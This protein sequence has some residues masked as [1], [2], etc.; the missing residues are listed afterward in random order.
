MLLLFLKLALGAAL[1]G[2]VVLAV[3]N[4][5]RPDLFRFESVAVSTHPVIIQAVDARLAALDQLELPQ[6]VAL[7]GEQVERAQVDGR[8]ALLSITKTPIADDD[9]QVVVTLAVKDA[10]RLFSR[11][12]L[13]AAR[14]FRA[15]ATLTRTPLPARDLADLAMD[16]DTSLFY[17]R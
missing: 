7:P 4:W 14:G 1:I 3:V 6:L 15:S 11:R 12:I 8:A 16:A 9:V 13:V 5:V 17:S 10:P 2:F